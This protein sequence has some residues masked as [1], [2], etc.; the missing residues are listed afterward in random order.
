MVWTDLLTVEDVGTPYACR[1]QSLGNIHVYQVRNIEHR[2]GSTHF[3]SYSAS[4]AQSS[5][6]EHDSCR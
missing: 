4:S 3:I 5:I 2:A 1:L 6:T